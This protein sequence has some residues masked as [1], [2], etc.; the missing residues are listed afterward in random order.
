MT[1]FAR[2]ALI[3]SIVGNVALNPNDEGFWDMVKSQLDLIQ[4]ELNEGYDN[5][6]LRNFDGLR[7]DVCDIL[8]T[9]YGLGARC[10][11]PTDDDYEL[12]C[13]SNMSKFDLNQEDAERT[14]KQY[15]DNHGVQTEIV[16]NTIEG[17][18]YYVNK[19]PFDQVPDPKREGKFKFPRGKYLKSFN[20]WEPQYA[21]L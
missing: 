18:T 13:D 6:E 5:L 17:T 11:F 10:G 16:V 4:S 1:N 20:F 3:N 7:D 14:Q 21:P 8:F 19:S 15:L 12:V 9:G 2:T